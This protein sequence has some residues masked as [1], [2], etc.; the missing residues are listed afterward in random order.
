MEQFS[1]E[2]KNIL[3]KIDN[4]ISNEAQKQEIHE[5]EGDLFSML[6][7]LGAVCLKEILVKKGTGKKEK[8]SKNK[9][10]EEVPF[11]RTNETYYQ[12]I[13]GKISIFKAYFWEYGKSGTCPLD[14]ELNMPENHRSYLLDKWIQSGVAYQAYH[15][16]IDNVSEILKTTVSKKAEEEMTKKVTKNTMEYY[17][18]EATLS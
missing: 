9:D 16:A 7:E 12:S 17:K 1:I 14:K 8:I 6:L 15:K 4:Y 2:K 10:G 13:F 5:M 11:Y 18:E 3:N